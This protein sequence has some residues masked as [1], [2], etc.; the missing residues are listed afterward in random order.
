MLIKITFY[1]IFLFRSRYY[2]SCFVQFWYIFKKRNFFPKLQPVTMEPIFHFYYR[3]KFVFV[4]SRETKIM[5]FLGICWYG[6]IINFQPFHEFITST[7]RCRVSETNKIS[8]INYKTNTL[9]IAG[10][11]ALLPDLRQNLNHVRN[12]SF[13]CSIWLHLV[14][15]SFS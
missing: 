11:P 7:C 9:V 1:S 2:S 3:R 4:I 15:V 8:S 10:K 5:K 14:L 13:N 6:A 12:H